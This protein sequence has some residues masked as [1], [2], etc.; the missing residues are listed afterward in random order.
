MDFVN[1][2]IDFI[3]ITLPAFCDAVVGFFQSV[4]QWVSDIPYLG[5]VFNAIIL[6]LDSLVNFILSGIGG[7][8]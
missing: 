8:F 3:L 2:I 1:T 5:E 7:C 6:W 4:V